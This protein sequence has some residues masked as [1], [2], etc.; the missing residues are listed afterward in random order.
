MAEE[1]SPDICVI[2]GGPGGIALAAAAARLGVPVVLVEKSRMGGAN[3]VRGSV[4][5]KA[6]VA[7]AGTRAALRRA[8]GFGIADAPFEVDFARLRDHVAEA[9]A[10]AG[11]HV[12]AERLTALGVQVL[13][14]A[15]TFTDPRTVTMGET[16]IR[17][18]RFVIA[19]GAPPK[20][21][22]LPGLGDIRYLTVE[23]AFALTE[24]PASLA[25]YGDDAR[26]LELA[27]AWQRLGSEVTVL[28]EGLP[29]ADEDPELS[30]IVLDRLRAE[31]VVIRANVT[32]TALANG[33]A[34]I[35]VGFASPSGDGVMEA[36][37]VVIA[38][39]RAVD[40][41]GLGLYAGKVDHEDG[42]ILVN[43]N[44]RT[45]NRRVY[46]IGDAVAGPASAGRAEYEAAEVLRSI[47]YRWPRPVDPLVVP[48]VTFTDPALA[49]VGMGEVE[50]TRRYNDVHVLRWP[51]V[52]NEL[53]T[54]ERTKAGIIKVLVRADGRILGA[55]IVGRDA[56]ELIGLWSF[57]ISRGMSISDIATMTTPYPSRMDVSR[58]V[59][60]SFAGLGQA[61]RRQRRVI[62]FLRKFG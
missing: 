3:L 48:V 62:E 60:E 49:R 51:F 39:G 42:L 6:L 19:A 18:R 1:L 34:G 14:G 12:S 61:P 56:G 53:A 46:A 36:T 45:S 20:P 57:A 16:I 7:A 43:R 2:G 41:D 52:E 8:P 35:R 55:A 25:V 5:S 26:S 27:L 22:S 17:A 40:I 31:G 11:A 50:A 29:L 15:A 13:A 4:P 44:R 37:Q 10:S 59:A 38:A 9:I 58:R 33:G 24:K 54:A 21:P 23:E 32:V 28:F 30:A 47:L